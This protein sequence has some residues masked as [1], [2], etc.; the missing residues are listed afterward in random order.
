MGVSL[1][2]EPEVHTLAE[3]GTSGGSAPALEAEPSATAQRLR[4]LA[5]ELSVAESRERQRMARVLHDE[6]GQL[7][8]MAQFRLSDLCSELA[9]HDALR[10]QIEDVRGLLR[11]ASQAT[12]TATYELHSP[13]LQQ[14]G[15]TAAIES[16]AERLQ[17]DTRVS[18][19]VTGAL[20]PK[21][22]A[23]DPVLFRVVRELLLNVQKHA[24]AS[25][26]TVSL[27]ADM[28]AIRIRIADDGV[29]FDAGDATSRF[30]P[31]GG[32]GLIS[33]QAQMQG[34]GGSLLIESAPGCGAVAVLNMP[35]PGVMAAAHSPN[36]AQP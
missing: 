17:R 23:V 1:L 35:L 21:P 27:S 36:L 6:V 5:F 11:E 4:S 7:L 3:A 22:C 2:A 9:G 29:G 18:V 33:A 12:R 24:R 28:H 32:F 14:L 34:L 15:L 31:E 25:E 8:A 26:V 19:R 13:V 10:Q 16:L 30:S 20:P